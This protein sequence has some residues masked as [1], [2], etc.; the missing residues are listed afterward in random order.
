MPG[1]LTGW[2]ESPELAAQRPAR[3]AGGEESWQEKETNSRGWDGEDCQEPSGARPEEPSHGHRHSAPG[4][5]WDEGKRCGGRLCWG[6]HGGAGSWTP[7][8]RRAPAISE[9]ELRAEGTPAS[10]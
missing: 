7:A 6:K 2:G 3:E 1:V 5:G 10:G 8:T 4:H 9:V